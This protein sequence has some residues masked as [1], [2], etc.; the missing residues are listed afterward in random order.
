MDDETQPVPRSPYAVPYS[1]L[2]ADAQV[3]QDQLVTVQSSDVVPA[4]VDCGDGDG[5]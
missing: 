1:A 3:Q 2:V 4:T 5:D